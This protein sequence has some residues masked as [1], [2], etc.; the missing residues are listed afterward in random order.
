MVEKEA[1]TYFIYMIKTNGRYLTYLNVVIILT[2]H[3]F[4]K[5]DDEKIEKPVDT[6]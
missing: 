5:L 6:D 3:I 1:L 2:S 4:S